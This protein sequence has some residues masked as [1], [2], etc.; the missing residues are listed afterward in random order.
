MSEDDTVQPNT[1]VC[2]EADLFFI[3]R[4]EDVIRRQGGTPVIVETPDAFV[5]AVDRCFPVLAL[6]D[7][8]TEGDW[9]HAITRCK[10]R[11]HTSQTPII[12]FGSHVDVET[13]R[14]ARR[15][16]ADHAWARSKLM[17]E[18]PQVV[19]RHLHP[20]VT[21]PEGWDA[22][23]SDLARRGVEELNAGEYFEQHEL[24]EQAW[25]AET[26]PIREMYQGILQVGVA[27]L[28]IQRNNW[29]GAIKMFRRGLPRLRTLPPVCQGVDI[30][31]F[32]AAAEQIHWE[33]T[34]SEPKGLQTFDQS[35]FPQIKLVEPSSSGEFWNSPH[36]GK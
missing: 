6:V 14:A 4:L 21:Y 16:G 10:I 15:A 19:E 36:D 34:R 2:L 3:P 12:A 13:L 26:R 25:M 22:P 30:A 11:P 23:L 29:T 8:A 7:L 28:Q 35:R 9:A 24:L 27:F 20:P 17:E 1:I 33:L 5:D 32:R 18:L 31:S